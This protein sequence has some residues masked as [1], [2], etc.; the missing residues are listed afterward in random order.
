ME[1][2]WVLWYIEN[3]KGDKMCNRCFWIK[4]LGLFFHDG[5]DVFYQNIFSFYV[6]CCDIITAGLYF[7]LWLG[8]CLL[9][10]A[11]F[12]KKGSLQLRL[13]F[14]F[15]MIEIFCWSVIK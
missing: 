11:D 7:T 8:C 1:R 15:I 2:D 12:S 3:S 5:E 9:I 14:N 10:T 13:S 6:L 4:E